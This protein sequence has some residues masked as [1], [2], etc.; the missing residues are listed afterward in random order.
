MSKQQ[1]ISIIDD[2]ELFDDP[3]LAKIVYDYYCPS[4]ILIVSTEN[5]VDIFNRETYTRVK[6]IELDNITTIQ[7]FPDHNLVI[8][9][10]ADDDQNLYG[11]YNLSTW[12]YLYNLGYSGKLD[13]LSQD[14]LL[15]T[16]HDD[17]NNT[18]LLIYDVATKQVTMQLDFEANS[19]IVVDSSYNFYFIG[20][21]NNYMSICNIDGNISNTFELPQMRYKTI[22]IYQNRLIVIGGETSYRLGVGS[23]YNMVIYDILA[24]QIVDI[25]DVEKWPFVIEEYIKSNYLYLNCG[26]ENQVININGEPIRHSVHYQFMNIGHITKDDILYEAKFD[27]DHNNFI[28][29]V[30]DIELNQ[31]LH[32]LLYGDQAIVKITTV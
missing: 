8:L 25:I 28:V 30:V 32:Q 1:I 27:G 23:T 3:N 24:G 2:L 5:S 4:K 7:A 15:I 20:Q 18:T 31:L 21:N 17:I 14:T 6:Q 12:E 9:G 22:S 19:S 10:N 16:Q 26:N 29:D 11:V 13:K